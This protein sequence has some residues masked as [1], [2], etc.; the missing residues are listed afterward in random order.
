M[1]IQE[2]YNE[3]SFYTLAHTGK[4]FIHQHVVDA[5]TAQTADEKTKPIALWFSLAGLYLFVEKNYTSVQV[6]QAHLKMA[7]R[8]KEFVE[9]I[10][11]KSRGEIRINDILAVP[12]GIR[13]DEM[14]HQWCISVWNA[15][16]NQ[17]DKIILLTEELLTMKYLRLK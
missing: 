3:L 16:L 6:Q 4:N 1:T 10:L 11:P 15:F 12:P 14:I 13:R 2:Q 5:Y 8:K 17:R 7:K 9:I